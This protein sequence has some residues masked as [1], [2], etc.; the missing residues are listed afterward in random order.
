MYKEL[1]IK[2]YTGH[3]DYSKALAAGVAIDNA[4]KKEYTKGGATKCHFMM[5][6]FLKYFSFEK[7][8]KR[9]ETL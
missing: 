8:P 3:K 4:L 5:D 1:A 9:N 6:N 7:L 2:F